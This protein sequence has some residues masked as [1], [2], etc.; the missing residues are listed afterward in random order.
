[1]DNVYA[2]TFNLHLTLFVK[3]HVKRLESRH[4]CAADA[5]GCFDGKMAG[6]G[7]NACTNC[8]GRAE[9]LEVRDAVLHLQ[10]DRAIATTAVM[11]R[12]ARDKC[13]GEKQGGQQ[14]CRQQPRE[15]SLGLEGRTPVILESRQR[16][17]RQILTTLS[18]GAHYTILFN[19]P[20]RRSARRRPRRWPPRQ[21]QPIQHCRRRDAYGERRHDAAEEAGNADDA[22]RDEARQPPYP[23]STSTLQEEPQLF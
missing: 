16:R 9:Q 1:M 2:C 22:L 7:E 11:V 12:L 19:A 18:H 4:R 23:S 21:V 20:P 17:Q 5:R 8:G 10:A 15:K 14:E 6:F 3:S 13:A